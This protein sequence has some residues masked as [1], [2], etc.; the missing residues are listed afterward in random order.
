MFV[1]KTI[2]NRTYFGNTLYKN[3]RRLCRWLLLLRKNLF[4]HSAVK[5]GFYHCPVILNRIVEAESTGEIVRFISI[6]LQYTAG[7]IA[8]QSALADNI[9]RLSS[10]DFIKS[11]TKLIYRDILKSIQMT[12]AVFPYG[13]CI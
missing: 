9:Y 12:A 2:I 13:S 5:C 8:A 4:I 10:F 7:N 3:S 11:F 1:N 6:A